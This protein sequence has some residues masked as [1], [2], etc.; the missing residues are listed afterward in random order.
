MLYITDESEL[1]IG[2][3]IS[4]GYFYFQEFNFHHKISIM[5]NKVQTVYPKIKFYAIDILARSLTNLRA[6][7]DIRSIPTIIIFLNGKEIR[8]MLSLTTTK[9]FKSIFVDICKDGELNAKEKNQ[10]N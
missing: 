5:I 2:N 3:G 1:K 6:R 10:Q 4:V 9:M 8:R 7:Y